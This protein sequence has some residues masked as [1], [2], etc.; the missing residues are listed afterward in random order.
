MPGLNTSTP[1]TSIKNWQPDMV[2][3]ELLSRK[4]S[5]L[6]TY[7]T[8]LRQAD[9]IT[10]E[11]YRAEPRS[12]AFVERY[13]HLAIE[14]VFDIA[15]HIIS[16]HGWREPDSYRDMLAI[17][18]EQQVVPDKDLSGFQEMASFRNILV[19]RY[20]IIDDEIVFGVFRKR[21]TDFQ[22][23]GD[24]IKIWAGNLEDQAD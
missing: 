18:H 17:L 5:F 13:L 23:F 21:L 19:H 8:E 1:G 16:F 10:W 20:E 22:R 6:E 12:R 2:D 11:R 9:D 4:L 24:L 14:A 3:K 15:N 7:I